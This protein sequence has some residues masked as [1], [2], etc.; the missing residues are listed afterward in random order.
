MAA[1]VQIFPSILISKNA[2]PSN[3]YS[4]RSTYV[5]ETRE[6][7]SVTINLLQKNYPVLILVYTPGNIALFD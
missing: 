1:R 3:I 6:K 7:L 4:K 5:Q 2:H